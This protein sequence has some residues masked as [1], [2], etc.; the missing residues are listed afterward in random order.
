MTASKNTPRS[1]IIGM[2]YV[3]RARRLVKVVFNET[4]NPTD[5]FPKIS[6]LPTTHHCKTKYKEIY[7]YDDIETR[8]SFAIA[9]YDKY[10]GYKINGNSQYVMITGEGLKLISSNTYFINALSGVVGSIVPICISI[11]AL[12]ISIIAII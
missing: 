2:K 10:L 3:F 5:P 11:I 7:G 9:T 4:N 12:V 8:M 6:N 1:I